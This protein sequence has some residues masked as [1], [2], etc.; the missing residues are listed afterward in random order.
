MICKAAD[1][2]SADSVLESFLSEFLLR[3]RRLR[4]ES[5]YQSRCTSHGCRR[6]R[7]LANSKMRLKCRPAP[8]HRTGNLE[9]VTPLSSARTLSA[10]SIY[11]LAHL[12]RRH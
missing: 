5:G 6:A 11:A 7:L 8:R 4:G 10:T 3:P 1:G 2:L 12:D 9:M